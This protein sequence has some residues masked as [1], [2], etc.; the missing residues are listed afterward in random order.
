M[1][2]KHLDIH[3][4]STDVTVIAEPGRFFVASAYTLATR[5]HSK[6]N[7][8]R[9]G[10]LENVMYFINDGVYGSFNCNIYDHKIVRPKILKEVSDKLFKSSIWGPT[11][12]ALD[13]VCENILLPMLDVDDIIVFENMG[14]YTI[15]IASPFNGFPLPKIEYYIERKHL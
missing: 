8:I 13:Q 7:I 1:I 12:D 15:P 9:N 10:N 3:F 6:R 5:I 4:P 11:C 2:S 14:A